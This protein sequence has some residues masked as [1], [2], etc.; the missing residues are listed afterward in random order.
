MLDPSLKAVAPLLRALAKAPVEEV[1]EEGAGGDDA[2]RLLV[3]QVRCGAAQSCPALV[4]GGPLHVVAVDQVRDVRIL[5]GC[6]VA[7]VLTM[8][9]PS[10]AD[11]LLVEIPEELQ[12]ASC[13][14][15][16]SLDALLGLAA[17]GQVVVAPGSEEGA[18][19]GHPDMIRS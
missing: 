9:V 7:W 10:C 2:R 5:P 14:S 6:A 3:R 18:W 13:L 1:R 12:V 8:T 15:P 4:K 11:L 19:P 16:S 17:S